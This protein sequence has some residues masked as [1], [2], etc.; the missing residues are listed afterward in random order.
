M[1]QRP[2]RYHWLN[3]IVGILD[4]AYHLTDVE[5]VN[6]VTLVNNLLAHLNIPDRADPTVVPALV[7]IEMSAGTYAS[8]LSGPR[9]SDVHPV[10]L[11]D[12]DD[13]VVSV[14]AWSETLVTMITTAYPDIDAPTRM[15]MHKVFADILD[16][17]GVP[18]R[19]ATFFPE[20]VVRSALTI[21][22]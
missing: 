15:I 3:T 6:V 10:R 16:A 22:A 21:D 20:D 11:A 7:A 8:L 9:L 12:E 4:Q 5:Q 13:I 19:A 1:T 17:L 18:D 14:E 2:E